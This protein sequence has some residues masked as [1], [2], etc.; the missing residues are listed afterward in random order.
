MIQVLSWVG[1]LQSLQALNGDMLQALDRTTLLFRFSLFFFAGHMIA[2]VC[3]LPFGVVGV[4]VAYAISSTVL[5]PIYG[6]LTARAVGISVWTYVGGLFGVVQ[7]ALLMSVAV[8]GVRV[9]LESAGVGAALRLVACVLV[10]LAVYPVAVRWR[11]PEVPAGG[12]GAMR[13]P[14]P[15]RRRRAHRPE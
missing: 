9:A 6:Y 14:P 13:E 11:A 1:L 10:G 4:A 3:G 7:A 5:E 2:F 12:P 8:L 15:G